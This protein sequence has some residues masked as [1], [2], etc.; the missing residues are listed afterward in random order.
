MKVNPIISRGVSAVNAF[1]HLM[2]FLCGGSEGLA[3]AAAGSITN[4]TVGE[5]VLFPVSPDG[6]YSY[7]V[8][9]IFRSNPI[10]TWYSE[11]KY[12]HRHDHYK[13]RISVADNG[14]V[15]LNTMHLADSGLYHIKMEYTTG[16]LKPRKFSDFN[17]Q[18][19][20]AC[21][22]SHHQN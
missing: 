17:L 5:S 13:E 12:C 1:L 6:N 8:D 7:I 9:L 14:S 19:F 10:V 22:Y 2:G 16:N 20:G 21:I 15:W 4:V 3:V 18:V 11:T